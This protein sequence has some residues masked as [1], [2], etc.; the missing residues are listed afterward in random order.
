MLKKTLLLFILS[1]S[2]LYAEVE[3][4]QIISNDLVTKNDIVIAT[5]N[6]V[7]FSPTYYITAQKAIYDKN[8][9]TFELFDDVVILRNN[10]I[11]MNSNY[12]FLDLNT[13]DMYQKPSIY[14]EDSSSI[15]ISSK[16]SQRKGDIVYIEDSILSSCDCVDPDWSIKF[17]SADYDTKDKWINAY[18]SRLYFKNVP[19][20]YF[21]YFGFSTDRT[22]RT[23]LLFP[24]VG[25]SSTEGAYYAQPLFI[26]PAQNYDFELVPQI[27]TSRGAGFYAYFRYA[28]SIN[29]MLSLSA[30]FFKEK[31]TYQKEHKLRND[32]HNGVDLNYVRN[33]ILSPNKLGYNDGLY[34]DI[35]YLNDSE[36]KTLEV[37]GDENSITEKVESKINYIYNTPSY[38]LGSYFRYYIDVS[39][40]SNTSTMQELPKLQA[41]SYTKP[42]FLDK[43][44]Y[45]TDI[46]YTN[47]TREKGIKAQQYELSLPVSYSQSFF[48]NYVNLILKH[49]F[50]VNRYSYSEASKNFDDGTYVESKSTIS[51]N[52]DLVKP[53]ENYIH[54]INL[55]A[56]LNKVEEIEKDGYLY[57]ITTT[58]SELQ[59]FTIDRGENSLELGINHSFY[60][61]ETLQQIVNHKLKEVILYDNISDL[62]T[63]YIENEIIYNYIL[64]SIS[65]RLVYDYQYR[66][67][68]ESSSSF[69]LSYENF[70]LL[71][72]HY[73]TKNTPNL[74]KE[75]LES[76]QVEAKYRFS[77]K[78]SVSYYTN[79]NLLDNLRTKQGLKFRI[80]ESC[81]DLD[82]KFEKE[83][84]ATSSTDHSSITQNAFYLQLYLKPIGGITQKYTYNNEENV[85]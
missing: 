73:L 44:V 79:Y 29:S 48:N 50:L 63:S 49:E 22:R 56:N 37:A 25:Y 20:L 2:F 27:R 31:E 38:F 30:G 51:L 81:W 5:G 69:S 67:V 71:L 10:N 68:A 84:I 52:S 24:T 15:W 66:K 14:F 58:D 60:D 42:I 12:A 32:N 83:L 77:D 34:V 54:T 82:I 9:G 36:Y 1:L 61:R 74:Q 41:H 57:N 70:Y 62:R 35:N 7:A 28:D 3:R 4:F 33:S 85:N 45:S 80:S 18:N 75:D 53:Y 8:K 39:K 55:F 11:Q 64:G 13:N 21:P 23:G 17:S 78:Y 47:H 72:G 19:L 26:A 6:V 65:N 40:E 46:K 43:L 16:D 59:P 76:Y